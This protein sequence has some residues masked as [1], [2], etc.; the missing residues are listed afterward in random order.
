MTV[1]EVTYR[2]RTQSGASVTIEAD[3][4]EPG[5]TFATFYAGAQVVA[6]VKTEDIRSIL[7]REMA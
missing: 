2:D 3:K 6:Y 7:R 5:S 1:F 4:V